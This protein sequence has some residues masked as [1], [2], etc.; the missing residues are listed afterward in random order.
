[1]EIHEQ[2][3]EAW[4]SARCGKVTASRTADVMAQ[5]KSGYAASRANYMAQLITERLTQTPTEGFSSTAM[6][7]G[8][9]TE[10]QARMAYELM[11]GEAVVETGFIPHPTIAGFGASP[12]GL[13]GSDGLIEIKCPNSATNI[14]TLLAGKVQS[15]Y[16]IQMQVQM[17]CCGRDWCDFVSFDPRMPGDMNFWMQR[18]HADHASQTDIKA[19]VIKF[20]GDLE[21]KLQ[22]LREKF[23][24]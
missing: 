2:R 11:T 21:M 15:K 22:Q 5:T 9:D 3:T 24:V 17:M 7:W 20:L 1:M 18:V 4:H 14:E 19:E 8:T 6:Q 12:D 16:M 13:V 23:N 10:P